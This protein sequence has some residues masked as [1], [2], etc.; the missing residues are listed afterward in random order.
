[1]LTNRCFK[2][3]FSFEQQYLYVLK[4][5]SKEKTLAKIRKNYFKCFETDI[6]CYEFHILIACIHFTYMS[7]GHIFTK[8]YTHRCIL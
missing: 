7:F 1:L 3:L 2:Q 8:F 4:L 6:C 5:L